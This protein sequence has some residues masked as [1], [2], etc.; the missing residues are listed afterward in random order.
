MKNPFL[1]DNTG[2]LMDQNGLTY[3]V[4]R[5]HTI[6]CAKLYT[7][8][9]L[10]GACSFYRIDAINKIG[11]PFNN[12]AEGYYDDKYL[13]LMLWNIGYKLLHVPLITSYHLGSASYS[14]RDSIIKG[15]RWFKGIVL[16]DVVPCKLSKKFCTPILLYYA[17]IALGASILTLGNYIKFFVDSLLES[18]AC[19][20]R[21][22]KQGPKIDLCKVPTIKSPL[23]LRFHTTGIKIRHYVTP[24]TTVPRITA[25]A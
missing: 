12:C 13:G 11:T 18:K 2:F 8:S 4:C 22:E 24:Y 23:P 15:P 14:E 25:M 7:P 17:L 5:G 6:D 1:I 3:P 21:P 20:I 19:L 9:F 10:S 16:A